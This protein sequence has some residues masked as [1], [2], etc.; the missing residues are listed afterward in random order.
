MDAA[1][2]ALRAGEIDVLS[3]TT[4]A[5]HEALQGV[6]EIEMVEVGVAQDSCG[7]EINPGAAD[8]ERM[9]HG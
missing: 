6:A 8:S 1:V 4:V 9:C 7:V 2:Q 5:E 3:C